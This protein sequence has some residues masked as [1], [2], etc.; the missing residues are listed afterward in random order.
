MSQEEAE[1]FGLVDWAELL[2]TSHAEIE[3][4]PGETPHGGPQVERAPGEKCAR[5]WKVLPEV[6]ENAEHTHLCR[7]CVS[8]VSA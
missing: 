5:C 3:L 6:G 8:V 2:I 7:R 4:L 1:Q